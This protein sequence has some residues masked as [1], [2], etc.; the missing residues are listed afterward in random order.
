MS[1]KKIDK[2]DFKTV[3]RL[4]K[5]TLHHKFKFTIVILCILISSGVAAVSSLFL[6]VLID[7]YISPLLISLEPDFS[8]LLRAISI[9]ALIYITGVI[10]TLMYNRLMAN[11]SQNILKKV[12]NDMF[13]HMQTLPIK[14]FDT[15]SHGDVMSCYTNDT[16]TLRHMISHSLPQIFSSMVTIAT[17]FFSM[18]YISVWLTIFVV[19]LIFIIMKIASRIL[20]KSGNYFIKQQKSLGD[21]NGYIEEMIKGQKVVKVFCHEE[22]SIEKFNKKNNELCENA[23]LAN[24]Y[25]NILM[26][27]MMNMGYIL[28][29]FL[30]IIGGFM[31]INNMPNFCLS[32]INILTLGMIASFLQLSMNFIMPISQISQQFNSIVTAFAGAKRI[33]ELMDEKS[34]QDSG[35]ID[36]VFAKKINDKIIES[37]N[38]T[39][40]WAWK[41]PNSEGNSYYIELK[42]NIEFENVDFGYT[43]T[44]NVLH[45]INLKALPGEQ[46]ALVGGTGAGKTTIANL[47]NRFYDIKSGII[48]YDG[49]NIKNIKKSALRKSLGVV[50]QDINLFTGTIME[51]IR[52]GR[53]NATDEECINAAKLANADSFIR[54]LPNGYQTIIN[55]NNSDISQGQKQLISIARAAVADSPVM[56]L[57]E[58]T[59]SVDTKTESIIQKGM[60]SLMKGRTIFIIAHRLS[61]IRN[62][63]TIVVLNRGKIAEKGNHEELIA[64]KGEYYQFYTGNFA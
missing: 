45:N 38:Y 28:Y 49:I 39:G 29:V 26:P 53:L 59:S 16:D 40:F 30:A 37:K 52:Y 12:R 50:L 60:E 48:T 18:L 55:G 63:D 35:N 57:D 8:G 33:F 25:A 58:A 46:I 19:L 31:A 21:I 34:E 10:S 14:Y 64:K 54:M 47:I 13:S 5:Y 9:M 17:I 7:D 36:L 1:N 32:G 3:K 22:K 61:T 62:S 23:T 56:I 41:I 11:I 43:K 27:S 24:K 15:H 2:I 4:M 42:G 20:N 6:Q 51:N 44:K